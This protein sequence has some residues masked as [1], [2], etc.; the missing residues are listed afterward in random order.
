MHHH[1]VFTHIPC[2]MKKLLIAREKE[3]K[4]KKFFFFVQALVGLL[5]VYNIEIDA[6][7]WGWFLF[8]KRGEKMLYIEIFIYILFGCKKSKQK[9]RKYFVLYTDGWRFKLLRELFFKLN[10]FSEF[11]EYFAYTRI[12]QKKCRA[13]LSF[14]E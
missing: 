13:R 1:R 9:R 8:Y 7:F 14:Y 11:F 3:Q 4:K 10:F 2:C 5:I 12:A 6:F